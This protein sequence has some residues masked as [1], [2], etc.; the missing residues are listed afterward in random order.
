MLIG[1]RGDAKNAA[2][3]EREARIAL[4]IGTTRTVVNSSDSI[5]QF[6]NL[7]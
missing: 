5:Q 3:Q 1:L 6:V 2:R 4:T 7:N